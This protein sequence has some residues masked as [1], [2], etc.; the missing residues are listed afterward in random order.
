MSRGQCVILHYGHAGVQ[1]LSVWW[2]ER[3]LKGKRRRTW[4]IISATSNRGNEIETH[5]PRSRPL[6][7]PTVPF[8]PLW[9][10][11]ETL[12]RRRTARR[13]TEVLHNR[14]ASVNV[15]RIV[16]T[17]FT[18]DLRRVSHCFPA[19]IPSGELLRLARDERRAAASLIFFSRDDEARRDG[20]PVET[21]VA[22]STEQTAG[23]RRFQGI[24]VFVI[25][26]VYRA[27]IISIYYPRTGKAMETPP[28]G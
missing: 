2:H 18:E 7:R 25:T 28:G 26:F 23:P 14:L 22:S 24:R 3:S 19:L 1:R 9:R 12:R 16:L 10:R 6:R 21:E 13:R 17:L 27:S 11:K 8:I 4:V 15:S 5:S 20:A